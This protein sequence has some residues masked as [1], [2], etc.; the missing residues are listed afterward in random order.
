[1][2]VSG[3]SI[4]TE[5]EKFLGDPYVYGGT[6]PSGFDCSGLVQYVLE[7]LGVSDVPRTSEEQYAWATKISESDLEPGDLIFSQWPGDGASPGH[8]AIYAGNGDLIEA[9]Q[10]GEDVHKVPFN[11]SYQSYVVG[12]GRVPGVAGAVLTVAATG[13]QTAGNLLDLIN[14]LNWPKDFGDLFS[15]SVSPVVDSFK[16]LETFFNG[17]LWVVNPANWVRIFAAIAGVVLLALGIFCLVKSS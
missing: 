4:V 10:P 3:A 13:A 5:A 14:P 1:M 9:P 6:S 7:H 8:V 2:T 17:L 12:Y 16:A 15:K 11:S